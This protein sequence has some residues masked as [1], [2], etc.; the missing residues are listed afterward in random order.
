M[1]KSNGR[2]IHTQALQ[3]SSQDTIALADAVES[4]FLNLCASWLRVNGV[5]IPIPEHLNTDLML[6][7][8]IRVRH[9]RGDFR[10]TDDELKATKVIGQWTVDMNNLLRNQ[11]EMKIN[12]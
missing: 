6:W 3:P 1:S 9:K 4:R 2:L 10:S 11:P 7:R 5:T 8:A 12:W